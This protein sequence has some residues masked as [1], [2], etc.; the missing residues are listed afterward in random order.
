MKANYLVC[1]DIRDVKRL[2]RV[3]RFMKQRG[4]HIQ[5]SVFYCRLTWEELIKLRGKLRDLIN[6]KMDDIRIYPLP[7]DLKVVVMGRGD[8]VPEGVNIFLQ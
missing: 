7:S 6:E 1:Y 2:S 4:V 5:Y 3:F 8:R